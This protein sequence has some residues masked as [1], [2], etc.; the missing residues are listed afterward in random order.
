MFLNDKPWGTMY[1]CAGFYVCKVSPESK[2]LMKDW[3]ALDLPENNIKH[4]WEQAALMKIFK[5]YNIQIIDD[6]MFREKKGQFLRHI[7]SE[8]KHNRE[9]YFKNFI[10]TMGIDVNTIIPKIKVIDYDTS[11]Y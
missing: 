2:R 9:P 7:G 1:P 11:I 10:K 6:W 8:E 4:P 3:Y 5:G